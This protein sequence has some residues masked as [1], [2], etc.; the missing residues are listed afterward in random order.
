[1]ARKKAPQK[2]IEAEVVSGTAGP[3]PPSLDDEQLD[4]LKSL[5]PS[6]PGEWVDLLTQHHSKGRCIR[7]DVRLGS[8][9]AKTWKVYP[10]SPAVD[11]RHT[12]MPCFFFGTYNQTAEEIASQLWDECENFIHQENAHRERRSKK[13]ISQIRVRVIILDEEHRTLGH[14]DERVKVDDTEVISL[15]DAADERRFLL[16]VVKDSKRE[17]R[18]MRRELREAQDAIRERDNKN[19][20][21]IDVMGQKLVKSAE[22]NLGMVRTMVE[23]GIGYESPEK[24]AVHSRYQD[25]AEKAIDGFF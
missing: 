10:I 20:E 16:S 6:G 11:E 7:V 14:A 15:D 18:A 4:P 23:S 24:L 13:P 12:G 17:E 21:N 8:Q 1:M 19:A 5:L 22:M 25:L 9:S 3:K 2:A